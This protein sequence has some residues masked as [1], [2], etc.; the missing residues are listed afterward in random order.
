MTSMDKNE[1]SSDIEREAEAARARLAMTLDQLRDNLTPQHI[2]E[3][4]M[5]NARDSASVVLKALGETAAEN[6]V[7]ALLI[8]AACAMFFSSG[9]VFAHS[10]ST[11]RNDYVPAPSD[12][13]PPAA[14][15]G[16]KPSLER[17]PAPAGAPIAE[18]RWAVLGERPLVT[19]IL[20]VVI[21]ASLAA[22][23]TRAQSDDL[24]MSEKL[25]A[26]AAE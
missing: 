17:D 25:N 10:P 23:L 5:G 13:A 12:Y 11:A 8:G 3:E 20:G 1:T 4:L 15:A 18:S 19:A 9:K 26:V 2:A 21:G 16:S 7:P 22:M 24:A 14:Y 6:P